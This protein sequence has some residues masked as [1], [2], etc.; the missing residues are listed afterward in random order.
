MTAVKRLAF[1]IPDQPTGERIA[2]FA[3]IVT[4]G[5]LLGMFV[6][7]LTEAWVVVPW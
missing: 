1:S 7:G 4:T 6:I 2:G 3:A 5:V